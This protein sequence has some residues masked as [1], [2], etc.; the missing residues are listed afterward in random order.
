LKILDRYV[1][2][3]YLATFFVT[4]LG[5][6]ILFLITDA[7]EKLDSYLSRGVGAKAVAVSYVYFF[8]QLIFWS[9]PIAALIAT[10]FTIGNMSRHQEIT[11]TKAGG[12]SFYRIA[13]PVFVLAS[14]LSV[15]AI[16]IGEAVPI[17]NQKRAELLGE[18][19]SSNAPIRMNLV[20]R[21]EDGKTLS[22]Y[23]LNATS[24]SMMN[25]V[26]E[27]HVAETG[28]RVVQSAPAAAWN[29]YEGWVLRDGHVR[30]RTADGEES[31]F[32]YATQ[33]TPSLAETPEDLLTIG[34]DPEEMRY[35][36][37]EKFIGTIDRS[38]G[39]SAGYR[40]GLAQK[41]S[42]PLAVL[43]IVLFGAPLSSS[44]QR[45]GTAFGV[46]IS[47]GVTLVYLMMFKV[48]EAIGESGVIHPLVAAWAPNVIFFVA[49]LF[50]L[51]RVRT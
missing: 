40:V 13:F 41:I 33:R 51:F 23:Q 6:P 15:G 18:R 14:F 2:R 46:G 31:T 3:Q 35:R 27:G 17:A 38:G 48:A 11:A 20:Y 28:M 5:V 22:T 30:W 50:L 49:A 44:T 43:V 10:V 21:T 25:V 16:A 4:V 39:E 36:E 34:K 37:L 32:T 42:L 19:E 12:I 47:L 7:T 29:V 9:F 45:G 26:V 1:I 24:G 8:P